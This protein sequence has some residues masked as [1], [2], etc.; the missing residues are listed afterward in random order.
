MGNFIFRATEE[1]ILALCALNQWLT[2]RREHLL[3]QKREGWF[4][5]EQRIKRRTHGESSP[6]CA[7]HLRSSLFVLLKRVG[8]EEHFHLARNSALV[9][10]HHPLTDRRLFSSL[11]FQVNLQASIKNLVDCGRPLNWSTDS[12]SFVQNLCKI[13]CDEQH[14]TTA[15]P[16]FL[17]TIVFLLRCGT[18]HIKTSCLFSVGIIVRD[19]SQWRQ[20]HHLNSMCWGAH[21]CDFVQ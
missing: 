12:Q 21:K 19:Q 4:P 2:A 8:G 15:W 18:F 9:Y 1:T 7:A 17:K 13:A 3:L 16:T 10:F 11:L 6:P 5:A 20:H 14:T